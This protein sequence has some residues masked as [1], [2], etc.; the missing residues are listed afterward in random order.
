MSL[1]LTS[2]DAVSAVGVG[3]QTEFDTPKLSISMQVSFTGSPTSV[4]VGLEGSVDGQNF[5][6]LREFNTS[7]NS[8]G[9]I[10]T[11]V[12]ASPSAPVIV[13][14]AN[15]ITLTGGTSPTVTATIAAA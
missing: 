8:N 3:A 11:N 6:Q 4:V 5:V 10:V 1:L 7:Q 12:P 2:L 14:R 9:D 15:L 13:A